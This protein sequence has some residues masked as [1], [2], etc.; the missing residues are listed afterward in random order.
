MVCTVREIFLFVPNLIG[1]GRIALLIVACWYMLN[2]YVITVICYL[3]S[4]FLDALDG[5]AARALGQSTKFG[6]MLDMLT[7]R[8]S[9]AC[10]LMALCVLYPS[11]SFLFQMSMALDIVSH[12]LHLHVSSISGERSHKSISLEG[13]PILRVYYTSRVVLFVMCAGNELFYSMLYLLAHCEGPQ[14]LT[15]SLF[16][17]I[18]YVS[19]PIWFAK[20]AISVIHLFVASYNIAQ[21]DCNDRNK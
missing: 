16:R 8:A 6:A 3:V 21:I 7:D 18:L 1:H 13:N 14:F 9:T 10:F 17:V 12:W 20:S 19:L 11:Y 5:H 15:M 4:H 2:N